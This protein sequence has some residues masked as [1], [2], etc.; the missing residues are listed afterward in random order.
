MNFGENEGLHFDSLSKEEKQQYSDINYRAPNGESWLEVK[1]RFENHL[2]TLQAGNHL[3]FTHGGPITTLLLS[4]GV[5]QMPSN[6]S[7]FG[8]TLDDQNPSTSL[9]SGEIKSLEFEWNFPVIEEEI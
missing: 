3:I 9:A 6:C 1:Q 4:H 8:V 2:S 5:T 7:W